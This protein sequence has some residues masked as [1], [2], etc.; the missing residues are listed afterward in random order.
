MRASLICAAREAAAAA[1]ACAAAMVEAA[2]SMR[3]PTSDAVPAVAWLR[4]WDMRRTMHRT[5]HQ[6]C[7]RPRTRRALLRTSSAGRVR[8]WRP[9]RIDRDGPEA[10]A[11]RPHERLASEKSLAEEPERDTCT[12]TRMAVIDWI[13]DR[14]GIGVELGLR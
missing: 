14:C 1:A 5:M 7:L 11:E 12:S 10:A 3:L 13:W 6:R 8:G 4:A 2:L 9:E